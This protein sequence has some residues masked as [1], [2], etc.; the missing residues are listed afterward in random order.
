MTENSDWLTAWDKAEANERRQQREA[1]KRQRDLERQAKE[2]A[3]LSILEQARLEVAAYEAEIEV[4]LSVHKEPPQICDWAALVA[5]LPPVPPR[6]FTYHEQK[7]RQMQLVAPSEQKTADLQS[8][9]QQD[10]RDYQAAM[11]AYTAERAR[12]EGLAKLAT[13]VLEGVSDSYADAIVERDPFAELTRLGST[14]AAKI[15]NKRLIECFLSTKGRQAIPAE[16]KSLT[17]SGKASVKPM[18]RARFVE[19]YQDYVC[20]CV[21]RVARELFALLPVETLLINASAESIDT[22]TG[23]E[24]ER[25]FLSVI[26]TRDLLG[27]LDFD[28]LDPSDTILSLTHRGNLKASRKTGEFESIVPFPDSD[29]PQGTTEYSGSDDLVASVRRLHAELAAKCAALLP[30]SEAAVPVAGEI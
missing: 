17:A 8:A 14:V 9:Q 24:V 20:G 28:K 16:S 10:E 29:V 15:H 7:A 11:H 27:K 12:Q 6:R 23:G 22:T 2:R 1:K 25:P 21:L 13:R 18:P 26:I 5:A 30:Q 19:I 4:L 3:K